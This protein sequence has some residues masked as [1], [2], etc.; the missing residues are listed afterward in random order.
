MK[1][2][3]ENAIYSKVIAQ[4]VS[5]KSIVKLIFLDIHDISCMNM[6]YSKSILLSMDSTSKSA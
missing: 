2:E 1:N 4:N 5:L 3:I 6:T